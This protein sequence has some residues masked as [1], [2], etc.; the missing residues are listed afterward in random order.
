MLDVLR[1]SISL[2][3]LPYTFLLGLVVLYWTLYLIGA[4]GSD[5]LDFAGFLHR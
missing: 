5:A 4:L 1:E 2:V 3:N